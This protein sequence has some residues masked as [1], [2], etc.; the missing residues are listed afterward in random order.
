MRASRRQILALLGAAAASGVLHRVMTDAPAE[1]A[2]GPRLH[3]FVPTLIRARA[4]EALLRSTLP[5]VEI[6]VFARF[7]DFLASA[8][9]AAPDGLLAPTLALESAGIRPALQGQSSGGPGEQYVVLARRDRGDLNAIATRGL[10]VVDMVGRNSLPK[11]VKEWLGIAAEPHVVRVLKL[12]DLL[13]L[14]SLDMASG[15]LLP[16]RFSA[17]VRAASRLPLVEFAPPSARVLRTA[18]AWR[19]GTKN[20]AIEQGLLRAPLAV[21]AALGVETWEKT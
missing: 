12:P 4:L 13:P 10:G 16:A 7:A 15:I 9:S 17:E 8:S 20:L 2:A 6:V 19:G 11:V 5:G 14:L 1:A 21:R 3:V 18:L